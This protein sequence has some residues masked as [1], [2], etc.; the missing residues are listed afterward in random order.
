MNPFTPQNQAKIQQWIFG[1]LDDLPTTG[2]VGMG[3][4]TNGNSVVVEEYVGD[5]ENIELGTFQEGWITQP[6]QSAE[7]PNCSGEQPALA[8]GNPDRDL[9]LVDCLNCRTRLRPTR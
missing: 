2:P 5:C 1:I 6:A 4:D 3:M 7:C 8:H 9:I